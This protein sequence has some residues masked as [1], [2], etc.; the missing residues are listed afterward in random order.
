MFQNFADVFAPGGIIPEAGQ[1]W[2]S[3]EMARSLRLIAES[4]GEAF[5]TG[6]LAERICNHARQTGGYLTVADFARHRSSW[7]EPIHTDYRGYDV[8]EI[9]PSGQGLT[10][11]LALNILEGFEIGRYPPESLESYHL[12]IESLKLAYIDAQRYIADPEKAAVPTEALLSKTYAARR[13]ALI[14]KEALMPEA[15]NPFDGDTCY[16]CTA[17]SEGM[18]VSFILSTFA[19]FGSGVVVPGT[20]IALQNRG[21]GFSIDPVHP[22]CYAPEKRPYHTIIPGFLTKDDQP[23]GPFGVMGG[24]M[25]PQGHLQVVVKMVDYGLDPQAA[26]D[27]PRWYW[28]DGRYIQVEPTVNDRIVQGLRKRGHEVFVDTD[29]DFVGGGQIIGRLPNG[30]YIGG[31]ESRKDGSVLGH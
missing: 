6:E 23:I 7:V 18:M 10:A 26:L 21:R 19:S 13:R 3:G 31:T 4:G 15:G 22:N 28:G 12:Q 24:H 16:L 5:Y 27:A 11:L 1:L 8:W 17:D 29:I 20:G 2:R 30:V 14:G 9:P 25:Q